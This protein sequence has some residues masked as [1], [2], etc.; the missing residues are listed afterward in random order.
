MIYDELHGL[1]QRQLAGEARGRTLQPT[2]LVHEA[3]LRLVGGNWNIRWANRRQFFA[4]AAKAMRRLR[5]DDVRRRRRLKR[6]GDNKSASLQDAPAPLDQDPDEVLAVHEAL[7]RLAVADPRKAEV[8]M[9]RYFA[10]LTVDETAEALG[11]SP[12]T[13]DSDWR[14]ARLWL[15]RELTKG[16]TTAG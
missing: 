3:Y 9:L 2:A 12:R 1:A 11:L 8:V 6:G 7:D 13:V 5:V 14:F 15:R 4:I 16:D 10:G